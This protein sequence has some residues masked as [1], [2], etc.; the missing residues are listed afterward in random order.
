MQKWAVAPV[1]AKDAAVPGLSRGPQWRSCA[2]SAAGA[3]PVCGVGG[4]SA[5][6]EPDHCAPRRGPA[7]PSHAALAHRGPAA[8]GGPCWQHLGDSV[9]AR[10]HTA[11]P[12]RKGSTQVDPARRIRPSPL[13]LYPPMCVCVC[14][15]GGERGGRGECVL[16]SCVERARCSVAE[17]GCCPAQG[18]RVVR[19]QLVGQIARRTSSRPITVGR[20]LSA[21]Y[22]YL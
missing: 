11:A 3:V 8:R 13:C 15:E 17:L 6:R 5:Q 20:L 10:A 21:D 22:H 4:E 7:H 16:Q 14:V 18:V 2:C 12:R 1:R 19:R 9:V